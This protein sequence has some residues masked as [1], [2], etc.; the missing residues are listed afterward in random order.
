MDDSNS[1]E[2]KN[3]NVHPQLRSNFLCNLFFLKELD[4]DDL[5]KPLNEHESHRLGDKLEEL[6][7][8]EKL[9][10]T[11]PALW[12]ALW[13]MFRKDILGH[14]IV[15]FFLEFILKLSQPLLL[16]KLMNYYTPNQTTVTL[17]EAYIYASMIVLTSLL[18]V[19]TYH[20]FNLSLQHLGM[21]IRI[22]CCSVIYRKTLK[23]SKK[24]LVKTTIG[25]MINLLSN[26]VNRFDNCF[27]YF[28]YLWAAPIETVLIMYLLYGVVG[29]TVL[30]GKLTSIFRL[31]TAVKTDERV[32]IMS[33][34]ISGIQV[35]KMYTWEK[36]FSAL[37]EQIRKLEIKQIRAT[38]YIRALHI[39]FNKFITRTSVF[40]CILTYAF[41]GHRPN[42]EF[43]YVVSS[44]YN[45]LKSVMI[46]DFPQGISNL[47]ESLVSMK[48]IETFLLFDEVHLDTLRFAHTIDTKKI[49][50]STPL[51]H[52]SNKK[53]IGIYLQGVF[54][55]W[56]DNQ[57]EYALCNV[58]FNVGPK[59]LVAIVGPVGSGKT[60]LLQSVMKELPITAGFK[61][62]VGKVS[63]ASQ[64]PWLFAGTIKQNILFGEKWNSKKYEKVIQVCAL[65]R[66]LNLLPYGDKSMV[67]DRGVSLSGGQK[68]RINLARAV[69]KDADIYILDDPLSAVDTQV[70]KQLFED[71]ISGFLKNKC[72]I[73]VT[74]QLQY[75][76]S[77][78]KIYLMENGKIVTTGTYEEIQSSG[79]DFAKLF[80]HQIE[81]EECDKTDEAC[82]KVKSFEEISDEPSEIREYRNT[83]KISSKV[84]KIYLIAGGGW[85]C[86]FFVLVLF[87]LTQLA[88]SGADFFIKFWVN[89]EQNRAE[90]DY[91]N[92][93]FYNSYRDEVLLEEKYD[94]I[95]LS[96]LPNTEK[97][98][99]DKFF[100]TDNCVY[101]YSFIISCV[102][103]LTIAR[104]ISFYRMCMLASRKLHNNMFSKICNATMH[105]FNT[106]S[107]G[108]ILNRF[109]KDMGSIDES[110][111]HVLIDTVQIALNVVAINLVIATVKPW[112]LIPTSIMVIIFYLYRIVY[113][114]S[115]RNIKRME[116]T[117][118][119]PVFSHI[120]ASLQGLTTIRAFG[121]QEILRQEF[122][123]HQDLHSAAFYM[124]LS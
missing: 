49:T 18:Y 107:S 36:A 73:L 88:S 115:S 22:A 12:R 124:F 71:C 60:S 86:S 3:K 85:C 2:F 76:K 119:S 77:V 34:I 19:V 69:Y 87:V 81:E 102:I 44:F 11:E 98:S 79:R 16:G 95:I 117:T 63:Y 58:N 110:L 41:T 24:A 84:Y 62:V 48:R 4:E 82:A 114:A 89:L 97:N 68:A 37:V 121:A 118:R 45:I 72:T 56:V 38:T 10:N 54:A 23:L 103:V 111:P 51:I 33:E 28:H 104:S 106:N 15:L 101:V 43:V 59:Q 90:K 67:G 32:R 99:I 55:K 39:S 83:G 100:I 29:A 65:E 116:A 27:R 113:L 74:H 1:D 5:Y 108:R 20:S 40:L 61:D 70:G 7:K 35:I 42:A 26:D 8:L 64:E 9:N 17:E 105:F 57:Q 66:D 31:R 80:K 96:A 50:T 6:W 21:K 14:M 120:N 123:K 109:S 112:F 94:K 122:D 78:N 30:M 13:M 52:N 75:L 47:A 25:Q 46:T 92:D 93:T 53:S 91:I